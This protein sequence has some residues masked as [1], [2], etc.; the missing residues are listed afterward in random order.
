MLWINDYLKLIYKATVKGDNMEWTDGTGKALSKF[1]SEL[2]K[3]EKN[4]R[5]PKQEYYADPHLYVMDL[6]TGAGMLIETDFENTSGKTHGRGY[7]KCA[8][9]Q[10]RMP[11][12]FPQKNVMAR[13]L[14][15]AIRN[16]VPTDTDPAYYSV[17]VE[18]AIDD[19]AKMLTDDSEWS[20]EE[21]KHAPA[22]KKAID[23]LM[24]ETISTRAGDTL[25][26]VMFT[27][28]ETAMMDVSA[29]KENKKEVVL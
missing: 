11:A 29:I 18:N 1:A 16:F 21:E 2:T 17:V 19:I 7:R 5:D 3:Q 27:E 23:K 15:M 14:A 8:E 26:N 28:V 24:D 13:L 20:I 12:K 9:V 4:K 10:Q 22:L 6:K 25:L